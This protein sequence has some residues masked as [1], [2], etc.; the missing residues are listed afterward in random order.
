MLAKWEV[1][2]SSMVDYIC[3]SATSTSTVVLQHYPLT[4]VY[5]YVFFPT[6][7]LWAAAHGVGRY[8]VLLCPFHSRIPPLPSESLHLAADA[9]VNISLCHYLLMS[10]IPYRSW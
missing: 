4:H 2:G 9:G 6:G 1:T 3:D 7:R 10:L 5:A 8:R